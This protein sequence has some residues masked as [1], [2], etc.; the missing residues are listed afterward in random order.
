MAY[1]KKKK[2]HIKLGY[3]F[4]LLRILKNGYLLFEEGKKVTIKTQFWVTQI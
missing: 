4:S 1:I 2:T 3:I